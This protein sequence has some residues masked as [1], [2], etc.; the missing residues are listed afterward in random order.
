VPPPMTQNLRIR[1][2]F[3]ETGFILLAPGMEGGQSEEGSCGGRRGGRKGGGRGE[4]T[5]QTNQHLHDDI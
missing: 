3:A 4:M 1:G 5:F 2:L